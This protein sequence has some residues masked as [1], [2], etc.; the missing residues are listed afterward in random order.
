MNFIGWLVLLS[1]G[2]CLFLFLLLGYRPAAHML[3][4][5]HSKEDKLLFHFSHSRL[6]NFAPAKT[7]QPFNQHKVKLKYSQP[8]SKP[9]KERGLGSLSLLVAV[10]AC[11]LRAICFA[12]LFS[13]SCSSSSH[14]FNKEMEE[15]TAE[16]RER[17]SKGAQQQ[18]PTAAIERRAQP[19]TQNKEKGGGPSLSLLGVMGRSP[20]TAAEFHS[21]N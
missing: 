3:H 8:A 20:S 2:G 10:V 7:E 18:E 14:F 21:I 5:L 11:G 19:Q 15:K 4:S 17:A 13:L 6:I 9:N 16:R 1:L 12:L